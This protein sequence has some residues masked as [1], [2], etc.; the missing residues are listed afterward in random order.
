VHRV[1]DRAGGD[2]QP[3]AGALAGIGDHAGREAG[4]AEAA[5]LEG[6]LEFAGAAEAL[7]R[8]EA[9]TRP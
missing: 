1:A 4:V 7:G 3:Q 9:K 2:R 6:S 8:A 5:T